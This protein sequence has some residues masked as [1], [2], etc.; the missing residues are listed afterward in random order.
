MQR[1]FEDRVVRDTQPDRPWSHDLARY[2]GSYAVWLV[3]ATFFTFAITQRI[4]YHRGT[5]VMEDS[6][7][8]A[9]ICIGLEGLL[10]V[11]MTTSLGQEDGGSAAA[12]SS[13]SS[14]V[15]PWC[16]P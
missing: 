7:S 12:A 6:S 2:L 13:P 10:V 11:F 4:V 5:Q 8:W 3:L 9:G 16:F 1:S 15:W 14:W